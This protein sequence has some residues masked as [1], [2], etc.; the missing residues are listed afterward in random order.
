MFK[1]DFKTN[2]S[3]KFISNRI[4]YSAIAANVTVIATAILLSRTLFRKSSF[5]SPLKLATDFSIVVLSY[6]AAATYLS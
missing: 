1:E 4:F 2:L 5:L 6:Y 3:F